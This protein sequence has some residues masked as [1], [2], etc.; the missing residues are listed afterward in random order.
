MF[1]RHREN[2]KL[3]L[4][5]VYLSF[6]KIVKSTENQRSID[7]ELGSKTQFDLFENFDGCKNT[8]LKEK[9]MLQ[10][11]SDLRTFYTNV[12][13]HFKESNILLSFMKENIENILQLQSQIEVG[14]SA[15]SRA[16]IDLDYWALSFK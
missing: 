13:N 11:I 5:L 16:P 7:E 9:Y 12:K 8:Y 6:L 15:F 4:L 3:I 1:T 14:R 2:M 10:Q